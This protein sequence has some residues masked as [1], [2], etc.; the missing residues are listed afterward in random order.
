MNVTAVALPTST[1]LSC[2]PDGRPTQSSSMLNSV[3]GRTTEGMVTTGLGSL[4]QAFDL[5]N[6]SGSTQVV[7]DVT[8]HVEVILPLGSS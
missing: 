8:D 7:A 6:Q 4:S 3:A 2:W 5:F 1:F